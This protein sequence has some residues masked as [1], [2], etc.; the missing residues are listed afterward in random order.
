M[1]ESS[2]GYTNVVEDDFLYCLKQLNLVEPYLKEAPFEELY[3]DVVMASTALRI[4]HVDSIYAKLL[5]LIP[6]SSPFTTTV[7][8]HLL[9]LMIP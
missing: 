8:S 4:R 3:G 6:I 2:K 5:D 9:H 7:L 1:G